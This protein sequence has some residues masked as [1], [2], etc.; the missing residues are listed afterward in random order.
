MHCSRKKC[1]L[2]LGSVGSAKRKRT[3]SLEDDRVIP[4][5]S[6]QLQ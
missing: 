2:I 5:K 1:L 6:D 4:Y 3:L